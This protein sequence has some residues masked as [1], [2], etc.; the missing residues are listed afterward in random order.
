MVSL[1]EITVG[2]QVRSRDRWVTCKESDGPNS[3]KNNANSATRL[4]KYVECTSGR[5]RLLVTL[6]QSYEWTS[7]ANALSVHIIFDEGDLIKE[8][9]IVV[10]LPESADLGERLGLRAMHDTPAGPL[11]C[12]E[13][14][15]MPQDM[16]EPSSQWF[17]TSFEFQKY[18]QEGM[19]ADS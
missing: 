10:V 3:V 9:R 12:L 2:L 14:I 8:Y 17:E 7:G 11:F 4:T 1:D 15:A 18:T 5:F 19:E 16:E 6:S 13:K